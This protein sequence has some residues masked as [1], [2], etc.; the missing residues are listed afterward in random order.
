M[1]RSLLSEEMLIESTV[2]AMTTEKTLKLLKVK[3][4]NTLLTSEALKSESK[5]KRT[6][7]SVLKKTLKIKISQTLT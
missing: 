1:L 7:T 2:I 6:L 3:T 4:V 5:K